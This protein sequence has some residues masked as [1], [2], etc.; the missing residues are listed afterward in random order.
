MVIIHR[1]SFSK[2][3]TEYHLTPR[4]W[5]MGSERVDFQGTTFKD[6]PADRVQT[7]RWL[8]EQ[9]SPYAKMWRGLELLWESNDKEAIKRLRDQFGEPPHSL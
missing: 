1:M 3:Y 5:E 8:E 7:Y 2:E 6:A 4:G 9:T